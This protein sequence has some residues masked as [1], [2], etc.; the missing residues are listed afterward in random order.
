MGSD[1]FVY[2]R[3]GALGQIAQKEYGGEFRIIS[4]SKNSGCLEL[5]MVYVILKYAEKTGS[6]P[7][8]ALVIVECG[9]SKIFGSRYV[10]S[11]RCCLVTRS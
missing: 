6:G 1:P 3:I 10:R 11:V 4:I 9:I 2:G 7:V 5:C 8:I